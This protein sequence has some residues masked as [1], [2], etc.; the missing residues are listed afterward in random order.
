MHILRELMLQLLK[1]LICSKDLHKRKIKRINDDNGN[2]VLLKF[3][4][5]FKDLLQRGGRFLG[6]LCG[7]LHRKLN[8]PVY[9]VS[10]GCLIVDTGS[11]PLQFCFLVNLYDEKCIKK[12]KGPPVCTCL[13][14][15]NYVDTVIFRL[16]KVKMDQR[17][18][19]DNA[20]TIT[21]MA[22]ASKTN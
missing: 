18:L 7:K 20:N 22:K 9:P 15:E 3:Q 6:F 4:K 16:R 5:Q 19:M 17:K 21:D 8:V 13:N 12:N 1:T 2:E 10:F 14:Y 11:H